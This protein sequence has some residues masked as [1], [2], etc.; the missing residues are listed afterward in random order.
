[1]KAEEAIRG[2]GWKRTQQLKDI[3]AWLE[4]LRTAR[5]KAKEQ[6]HHVHLL[7]R[8]LRTLRYVP[9]WQ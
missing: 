5:N 3:G 9:E 8:H 4:E 7:P 1:M 2:G 6:E